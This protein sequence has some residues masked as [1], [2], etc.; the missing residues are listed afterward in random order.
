[1]AYLVYPLGGRTENEAVP[2][3]NWNTTK[4]T[5][6]KKREK[7]MLVF[8]HKNFENVIDEEDTAGHAKQNS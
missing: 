7:E 3:G 2:R 5:K 8:V 4:K 1:M 6:F